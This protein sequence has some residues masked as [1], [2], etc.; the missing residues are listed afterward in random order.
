M[1]YFLKYYFLMIMLFGL[2]SCSQTKITNSE[3]TLTA[4]SLALKKQEIIDYIK[5]F[6][7]SANIGCLS[8]AFGVK[9]CGGP[10]EY[11]VY[12][13]GI[14]VAQ[15]QQ[16]VSDYNAIN[17]QFNVATNAMSDCAIVNPPV[18][19]GCVNGQCG[20]LP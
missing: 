2:M 10:L 15:L 12:S 13:T 11:L 8:I 20:V 3:S 5:S 16:M 6:Q 4:A 17:Q 7:C 19:V 14:N 18:N 9:P 1:I